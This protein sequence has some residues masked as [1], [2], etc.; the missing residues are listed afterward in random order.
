MKNALQS[1]TKFRT[2]K[3]LIG[4]TVFSQIDY[5]QLFDI[6]LTECFGIFRYVLINIV[7]YNFFFCV[8]P[9]L[10]LEFLFR[11][12]QNY[13]CLNIIDYFPDMAVVR[14]INGGVNG[15]VAGI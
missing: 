14:L 12:D 8:N 7:C 11:L 5:S 4:N 6:R 9:K 10:A 15:L 13:G 2:E 3:L 1:K